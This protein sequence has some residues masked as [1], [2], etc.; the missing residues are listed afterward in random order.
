[1]FILALVTSLGAVPV[2]WL[3][4]WITFVNLLLSQP[5]CLMS[6]WIAP[7]F[8]FGWAAYNASG[9]FVSFDT[10]RHWYRGDFA[11]AFA[12]RMAQFDSHED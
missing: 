6:G 8:V 7:A 2:S 12:D 11:R 4:Q 3:W 5:S 9:V 10:I 1:M